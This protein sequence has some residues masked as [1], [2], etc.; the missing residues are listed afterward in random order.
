MDSSKKN[1]MFKKDRPARPQG[2]W[3]AEPT[4]VGEHDNGPRTQLATF[5]NILLGF[6]FKVPYHRPML[7]KRAPW[8]AIEP[9]FDSASIP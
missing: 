2:R 7:P 6:D 9:D 3:R 1:R 8:F 5:F 4:E